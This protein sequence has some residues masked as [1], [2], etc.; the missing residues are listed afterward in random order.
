MTSELDV[1]PLPELQDAVIPW[2]VVDQLL[3]DIEAVAHIHEV[4]VKGAAA[5]RARGAPVDLGGA[6][7]ALL[8]GSAV[9]IQI[10][11]RHAG[12]E[13]CDTLLRTAGG[14]RIVR[15]AVP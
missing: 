12:E 10:R 4:L 13:W 3:H 6:R 1:E 15:S 7:A 2:E 8:D 9:G 5:G 14:V 11:Y